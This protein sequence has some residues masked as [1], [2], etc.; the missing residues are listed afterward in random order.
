VIW[1]NW[2]AL[3]KVIGPV[4]NKVPWIERDN[5]QIVGGIGGFLDG[6]SDVIVLVADAAVVFDVEVEFGKVEVGAKDS[7]L[8]IVVDADPLLVDEWDAV[9]VERARYVP[10]SP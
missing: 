7:N 8:A 9:V 5:V 4:L 3:E 10:F 6:C 1:R 2:Q